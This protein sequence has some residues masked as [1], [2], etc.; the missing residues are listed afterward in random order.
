LVNFLSHTE[1]TP[2]FRKNQEN[3]EIK[4]HEIYEKSGME[5]ISVH[6]NCGGEE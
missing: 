4:K 5:G 6:G 2:R 1:H 3:N